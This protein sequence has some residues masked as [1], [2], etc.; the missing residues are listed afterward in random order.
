MIKINI[1][2]SK[3]TF[4]FIVLILT[5][6]L[7]NVIL[8]NMQDEKQQQVKKVLPANRKNFTFTV[9]GVSFEMIFVEGGTFLMGCTSEQSDCYNSEKPAHNVNLSDFYIGKHTVTQ[10]LWQAVMGTNIQQQRDSSDRNS[11]CGEGDD[12]PMYYVN[13]TECEEFCVKL[14]KL[15]SKQLPENHIFKLPSEAQW[16]YAARGGKR[17]NSYK[18]SGGNNLN[19]L[20]WNVDNS[21]KTT[22]L[23]GKKMPNELGIYD[24]SG[25]VW[26][27]SRDWYDINYYAVS[28]LIDPEGPSS[29]TMRAMRGGAWNEAAARCRTSNRSSSGCHR[30]N[31]VGFRICLVL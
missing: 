11:L 26:E 30:L 1:K 29:G 28:P 18:Y 19:N 22:H 27:W 8:Y 24:M 2:N 15:L 3:S 9:N 4:L 5:A 16:E 20:A 13:Y 31:K 7:S 14:T 10:K 23:V 6:Y 12:Y 21:G 17:S 25:N